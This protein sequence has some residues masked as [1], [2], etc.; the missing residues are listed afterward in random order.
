[1]A[2]GLAAASGGATPGCFTGEIAGVTPPAALL[3]P[4]LRELEVEQLLPS[5]FTEN[6]M[7]AMLSNMLESAA[8]TLGEL[9]LLIA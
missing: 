2:N 5:L 6:M 3:R 1:M 4:A 8:W 9:F 7:Y